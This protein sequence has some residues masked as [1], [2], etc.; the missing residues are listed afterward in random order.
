MLPTAL[1]ML[2]LSSLTSISAQLKDEAGYSRFA[3]EVT[4]KFPG[5]TVSRGIDP[6]LLT[7]IERLPE[8]QERTPMVD[9]AFQQLRRSVRVD[10][11]GHDARQ[12]LDFVKT[13]KVELGAHVEVPAAPAA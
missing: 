7:K 9:F 12:V 6:E 1:L 3:R 10:P 2:S 5:A 11:N 4:A 8:A 13:L